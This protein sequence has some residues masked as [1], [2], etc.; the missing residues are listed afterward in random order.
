MSSTS[1]SATVATIE[2]ADAM[3]LYDLLKEMES[4][5]VKFSGD[6]EVMRRDADDKRA[7]CLKAA[8]EICEKNNWHVKF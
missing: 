8:I 7:E 4:P 2:E 6:F 3:R 5:L 1:K